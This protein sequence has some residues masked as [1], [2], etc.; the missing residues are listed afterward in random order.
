MVLSSV[1][2]RW[3]EQDDDGCEL[4]RVAK[5]E[6][7][8]D[9]ADKHVHLPAARATRVQRA[10]SAPSHGCNVARSGDTF[11]G[12]GPFGSGAARGTPTG[13]AYAKRQDEGKDGGTEGHLRVEED[14]GHRQEDRDDG[15][16]VGH[17]VEPA[18]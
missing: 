10:K 2:L 5:D 3:G 12:T 8:E 9:V 6:R 15:A 7:L 4:E 16:H 1:R 14:E 18:R 17:E 13:G 11:G